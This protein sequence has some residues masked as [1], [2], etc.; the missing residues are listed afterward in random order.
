MNIHRSAVNKRYAPGNKCRHCFWSFLYVLTP[1][2]FEWYSVYR[3][4]IMDKYE[5][6]DFLAIIALGEG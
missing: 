6:V 3:A 2:D 5:L 1:G 4:K